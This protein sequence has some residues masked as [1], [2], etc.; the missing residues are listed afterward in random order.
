M[1]STK[2]LT[3]LGPRMMNNVRCVSPADM[4]SDRGRVGMGL[5][6]GSGVLLPGVMASF[7]SK[8]HLVVMK[9]NVP[10]SMV[11]S[12]DCGVFF[13][14]GARDSRFKLLSRTRK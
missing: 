7:L 4:K 1:R 6:K 13:P 10:S 14:W 2:W 9:E 12:V 3:F 11:I 8:T 5:G